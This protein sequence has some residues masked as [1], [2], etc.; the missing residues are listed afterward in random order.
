MIFDVWMRILKRIPN[1]VLWLLRFPPVGE[2]NILKEARERGVRSDQIIFSDVVSR[3]KHV[4]RGVLADLFLDTLPFNG[5]TTVSDALWAGL[6]VITCLGDSFASRMA[7]SLLYAVDLPELVTDSLND[8]ENL[9]IT[10]ALNDTDLKTI[11]KK[12]SFNKITAALFNSKL[13]T[14]NFEK[15]LKIALKKHFDKQPP[16][17]IHLS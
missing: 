9:A 4:K 5:G 7:G 17:H 14:A 6:P 10:L 12:L 15:G 11:R 16:D 3:E 8:Y 2:E 1:A 13:F